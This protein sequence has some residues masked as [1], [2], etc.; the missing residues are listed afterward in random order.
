MATELYGR[1]GHVASFPAAPG[2][3]FFWSIFFVFAW[4]YVGD[5]TFSFTNSLS[6]GKCYCDV[7]RGTDTDLSSRALSVL[8]TELQYTINF[9]GKLKSSILCDR[10]QTEG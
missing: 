6:H 4:S 5:L 7:I 1:H 3:D 8:A 10:L 2:S 9:S